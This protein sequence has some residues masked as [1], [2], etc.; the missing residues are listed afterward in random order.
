[1]FIM[2]YVWILQSGIHAHSIANYGNAHTEHYTSLRRR[3]EIN[4]IKIH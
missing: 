1:M 4:Y 3:N 2:L